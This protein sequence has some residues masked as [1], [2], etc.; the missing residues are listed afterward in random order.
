MRPL[1]PKPDLYRERGSDEHFASEVEVSREKDYAS[2]KR[3]RT[4]RRFL[5]K[6]VRDAAE[7]M[8]SA[9]RGV[10]TA[11]EPLIRSANRRLIQLERGGV[12]EVVEETK[13][14]G[15]EVRNAYEVRLRTRRIL[16]LLRLR[17]FAR[18]VL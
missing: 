8:A 14:R 6:R 15:A 7:T 11:R 12:R 9:E 13:W 1:S 17:E 3:K 5:R 16:V 2:G 4:W 18:P 10:G